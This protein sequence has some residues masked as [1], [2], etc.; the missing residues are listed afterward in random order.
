M[1]E[2]KKRLRW[3]IALLPAA[4]LAAIYNLA[5]PV[6]TGPLAQP[7]STASVAVSKRLLPQAEAGRET[8]LRSENPPSNEN[9]EIGGRN[10]FRVRDTKSHKP[11]PG[12]SWQPGTSRSPTVEPSLPVAFKFYG[13]AEKSTEPRRIFLQDSDNQELFLARLGDTVKRR[14]KV[15]EISIDSVTIEDVLR[16][17][18]Q[19]IPLVSR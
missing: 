19:L 5:T 17:H 9:Y 11:H 13:F 7:A 6:K 18:R 2:N 1:P 15:I 8:R 12:P 4:A 16:N 10:I 3:M 14:Y